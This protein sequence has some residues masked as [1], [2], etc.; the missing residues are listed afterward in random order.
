MDQ[1]KRLTRAAFT[2]PRAECLFSATL[3]NASRNDPHY[4]GDDAY[5]QAR[6]TH[7]TTQAIVTMDAHGID[8]KPRL[9]LNITVP[10]ENGTAVYHVIDIPIED[11]AKH[12]G[13]PLIALFQH[14]AA[15]VV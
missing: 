6:L 14:L 3:D 10:A 7:G 13:G 15:R 4:V 5:V 9:V 2:R 8:L 12:E 1:S 11:M